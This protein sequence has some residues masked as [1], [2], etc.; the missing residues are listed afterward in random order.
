[1]VSKTG[2]AIFFCVNRLYFF[3][4]WCFM[5]LALVAFYRVALVKYQVRYQQHKWGCCLHVVRCSCGSWQEC[6]LRL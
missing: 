2:V 1:M 4:L 3:A 6:P 5:L